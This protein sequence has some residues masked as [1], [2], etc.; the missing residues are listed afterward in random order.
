MLQ[1]HLSQVTVVTSLS[2]LSYHRC[3]CAVLTSVLQSFEK[4]FQDFFP[5]CV[6]DAKLPVP[7][8]CHNTNELSKQQT[9]VAPSSLW[10]LTSPQF[11]MNPSPRNSLPNLQYDLLFQPSK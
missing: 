8:S 1:K 5:P 10:Q 9:W 11:T 7:K 2:L 4:D 3:L 6:L